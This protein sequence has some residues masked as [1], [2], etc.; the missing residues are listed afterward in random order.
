MFQGVKCSD[1][2]PYSSGTAAAHMLFGLKARRFALFAAAAA[3]FSAIGLPTVGARAEDRKS[4]PYPT[5]GDV[6][7]KRENSGMT[8]DEIS[9][10]KKDLTA[11]R[12]RQVPKGKPDESTTHTKH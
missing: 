9:K 10:L 7:P 3:T 1:A 12:D 6:P 2:A 5:V 11:A 4:T 8:N